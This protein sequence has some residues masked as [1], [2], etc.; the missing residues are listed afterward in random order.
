MRTWRGQTSAEWAI[1]VA[2][3][4]ALGLLLAGLLALFPASTPASLEA[5][6]RAYWGSEIGP[7]HVSNWY[8]SASNTS[9]AANLTMVLSNAGTERVRVRKLLLSPGNFSQAY[10]ASGGSLGASTALDLQLLPRD[11][12]VVVLAQGAG[13]G[14]QSVP[15]HYSFNLSIVYDASF[16]SMREDGLVPLNGELQ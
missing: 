11:S 1:V 4:L 9:S 12:L 8:A 14:S 5:R 2:G 15:A 7:L 16:T 6:S 13:A 10:N 3:V